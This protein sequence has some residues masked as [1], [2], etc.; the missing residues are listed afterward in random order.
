MSSNPTALV[1]VLA[2]VVTTAASAL[3]LG[4]AA[5]EPAD[6]ST[7]LI[8]PSSSPAPETSS[9]SSADSRGP[10]SEADSS[11]SDADRAVTVIPQPVYDPMVLALLNPAHDPAQ[12]PVAPLTAEGSDPASP[13]VT[14]SAE[15]APAGTESVS[16]ESVS[17]D[18]YWPDSYSAD[19]YRYESVPTELLPD[20]GASAMPVPVP[21]MPATPQ[22]RNWVP[23]IITADIPAPALEVALAE[24]SVAL[25]AVPEPATT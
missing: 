24:P 16:T 7:A 25:P 20:G 12:V 21:S 9:A 23:P 5:S 18:S 6:R 8:G 14:D 1:A 2:L 11:A 13:D 4:S 19:S 15:T 22:R 10:V 3:V 17:T